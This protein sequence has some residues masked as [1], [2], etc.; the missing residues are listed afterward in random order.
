MATLALLACFVFTST[1]GTG[2][3]ATT[4]YKQ[5]ASLLADKTTEHYSKVMQLIRCRLSFTLLRSAT[6][7]IRGTRS[8]QYRPVKTDLLRL[9]DNEARL[10]A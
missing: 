3:E 8:S 10:T 9:I 2:P 6:L 4:F 5:L 7:C 1:G